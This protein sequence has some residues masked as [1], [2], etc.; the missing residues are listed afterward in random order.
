MVEGLLGLPPLYVVVQ[1]ELEVES[2]FLLTFVI[3]YQLVC[4]AEEPQGR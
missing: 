4:S 1:K 3:M 2:L